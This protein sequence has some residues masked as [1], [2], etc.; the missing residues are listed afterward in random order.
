MGRQE[1]IE[2]LK[3]LSG[4]PEDEW[5]LMCKRLRVGTINVI[6]AL[7]EKQKDG[8]FPENIRSIY[9]A[10]KDIPENRFFSFSL[11]D[12]P[13]KPQDSRIVIKNWDKRVTLNFPNTTP[14]QII[15]TFLDDSTPPAEC[16]IAQL[17]NSATNLEKFLDACTYI[18]DAIESDSTSLCKIS[19]KDLD[20]AE[21][22]TELL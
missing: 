17:T 14:D 21:E 6:R 12:N 3:R 2:M 11:W 7:R 20:V 22:T 4:S 1:A 18:S 13:H 10:V 9:I 19:V 8:K 16:K 15:E 5:T